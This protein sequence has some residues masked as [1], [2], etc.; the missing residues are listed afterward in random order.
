MS[1]KNKSQPINEIVRSKLITYQWRRS[2]AGKSIKPEHVG[3]LEE[4]AENM[5]EYMTKEGNTSGELL[6]NIFMTDDDLGKDGNQ[7]GIE[8]VGWW[9]ITVPET[10]G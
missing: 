7:D 1:K 5:I 6:D 9:K 4:T 3:A 10:E 2:E 8:Y